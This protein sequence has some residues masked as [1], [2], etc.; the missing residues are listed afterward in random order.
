MQIFLKT[1]VLTMCAL[2]KKQ[3]SHTVPNFF[4]FSSFFFQLT[5]VADCMIAK[6]VHLPVTSHT[7]SVLQFF[8]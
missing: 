5:V 3:K 6:R 1:D 8:L 7:V 4:F 2:K